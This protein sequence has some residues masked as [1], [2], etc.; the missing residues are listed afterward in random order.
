MHVPQTG[1]PI[2]PD[3]VVVEERE[4]RGFPALRCGDK[5]SDHRE[6]RDIVREPAQDV[7]RIALNRRNLRLQQVRVIDQVLLNRSRSRS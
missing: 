6:T 4:A 5:F 3:P 7:F 1:N 2:D